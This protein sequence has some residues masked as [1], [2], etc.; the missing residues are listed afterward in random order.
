M[1]SSGSAEHDRRLEQHVNCSVMVRYCSFQT[2]NEMRCDWC[3]GPL[4]ISVFISVSKQES[5]GCRKT[6]KVNKLLRQSQRD[7]VCGQRQRLPTAKRSNQIRG[8]DKV[9]VCVCVRVCR[10]Q[11][12]MCTRDQQLRLCTHCPASQ[13]WLSVIGFG[14]FPH[15]FCQILWISVVGVNLTEAISGMCLISQLS[16]EKRNIECCIILLKMITRVTAGIL[17]LFPFIPVV[18][19]LIYSGDQN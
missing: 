9:S 13:V 3:G 2:G 1:T 4:L 17:E 11:P 16:S 7:G 18:K 19:Y 10:F 14:H 6:C 8:A 5:M 12:W 15:V